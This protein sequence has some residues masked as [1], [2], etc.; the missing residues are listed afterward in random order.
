MRVIRWGRSGGRQRYRCAH[1]ERTFGET[2]GTPLAY[3]KKRDRWDAFLEC[4]R[5][6]MT[7]RRTAAAI[8]VHRDTAFRWRHR[9]LDAVRAKSPPS[10]KWTPAK[11]TPAKWTPA[12]WTPA[13]WTPAKWSPGTVGVTGLVGT[14]DLGDDSLTSRG[15][16]FLA[17]GWFLYSEKGKRYLG[18]PP[19]KTGYTLE[20]LR[21]PRAWVVV[22]CDEAGRAICRFTG[23]RRP[24]VTALEEVLR[25]AVAIRGDGDGAPVVI[26]RHGPICQA[27]MAARRLGLEYERGGAYDT[28]QAEAY[29]RGFRRWLRPFKGVATR[30]LPNYIAWHGMGRWAEGRGGGGAPTFAAD[31]AQWFREGYGTGAGLAQRGAGRY[32]TAVSSGPARGPPQQSRERKIDR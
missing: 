7:V 5:K 14:P 23:L 24:L 27:A 18:R 11:W 10:D 22:A 20:W 16:I 21:L 6:K 19:R 31:S 8:G 12:K 17:E 26:S 3:L 1:C 4:I 32:Y 9:Y 29:L 28:V 15:R 25:A 2:T 30:Y 13:K